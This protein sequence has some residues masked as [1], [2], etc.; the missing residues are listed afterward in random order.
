[1]FLLLI[2]FG[3]VLGIIAALAAAAYL[4]YLRAFKR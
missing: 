3:K 4:T 1:M 2:S